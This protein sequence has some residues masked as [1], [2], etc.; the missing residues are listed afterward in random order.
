MDL[1]PRELFFGGRSLSSFD[2]YKFCFV[3]HVEIE[4]EEDEEDEEENRKD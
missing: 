3:V 1:L 4:D 2:E